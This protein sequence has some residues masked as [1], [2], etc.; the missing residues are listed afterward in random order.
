MASPMRLGQS[1]Q[2]TCDL[3]STGHLAAYLFAFDQPGSL[4]LPGGQVLLALDGGSGELL[5]GGGLGP[6][7]GP[8]VSFR[9][10]V[11]ND[12]GLCGMPP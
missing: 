4:P 3:S 6:F 12:F 10:A 1:F 9:L 11:P 5:S 8:S 2:A 7:L